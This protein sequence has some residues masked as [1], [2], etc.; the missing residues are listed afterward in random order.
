MNYVLYVS[1]ILAYMV[2]LTWNI[3]PYGYLTYTVVIYCVMFA[4]NYVKCLRVTSIS[5]TKPLVVLK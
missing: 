1:N 2:L 3:L 4:N 5:N